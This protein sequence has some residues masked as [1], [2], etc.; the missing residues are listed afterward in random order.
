MTVLPIT[1]IFASTFA[2]ALVILSVPVSLQRGK[3][4]IK[5]GDS[6]D[7]TLRRRIR[8]QGNF[9]EYVPLGVILLGLV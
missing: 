3:V 2:I 4:G 7:E 6:T 8:T 5:V 1:P 9:I